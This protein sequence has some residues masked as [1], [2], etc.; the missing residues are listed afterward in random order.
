MT[1]HAYAFDW[2]A[3]A[4]DELYSILLDALSSGDTNGLIRYIEA[5]RDHLKDRDEGGPLSDNWQD[6]LENF[7]VH[8]FGDFALTRFFDPEND[9]GLRNPWLAIDAHLSEADRAVLLGTP[10]GS[11]ST[12]FD[13]SRQGSYFQTPLEVVRSLA[14]V[15]RFELP[16][17]EDY[18]R[19][20]LE[21][22]KGL[23]E[24]CAE[25][26]SGLYVTF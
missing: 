4:R 6:V 24:E 1:H 5:N 9:R 8:E 21:W 18:H 17:L 11:S 16:D 15:Q 26:G 7:D 20:S 3:F 25:D 10:F 12:Y 23:L 2:S 14:R 22:F 19:K 13:P